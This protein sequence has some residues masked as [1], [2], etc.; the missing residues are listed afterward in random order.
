VE[1]FDDAEVVI[2]VAGDQDRQAGESAVSNVVHAD[3]FGAEVALDRI[4]GGAVGDGS[5]ESASAFDDEDAS[6]PAAARFVE[7]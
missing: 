4:G 2:E 6:D 3:G 7:D 1:P 5:G